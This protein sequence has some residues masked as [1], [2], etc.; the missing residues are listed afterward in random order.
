MLYE[1][2]EFGLIG[3]HIHGKQKIIVD[4]NVLMM[5]FFGEDPAKNGNKFNFEIE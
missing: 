1:C 3:E 2:V 4:H 5:I